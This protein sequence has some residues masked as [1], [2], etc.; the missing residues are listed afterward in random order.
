MSTSPRS[1]GFRPVIVMWGFPELSQTFIHREIAGWIA[2]HPEL[3]ILAGARR[4]LDRADAESRGW[5]ERRTTWLPAP[6][7]WFPRGLLRGMRRPGRFLPALAWMLALPHRTWLHRLRGAA[8]CVAAADA[9]PALLRMRA[10]YLHAHFASYHTEW[11]MCLA[12]MAGVP[13]GG[14]WHAVDIWKDR[15]ILAE[16]IRGAALVLTCTR[17]NFGYLRSLAPESA[18]T[19]K[20]AYHGI[21]FDRLGVPTPPPE[22]TPVILAIGRLVEKKGFHHLLDA[23]AVL[24]DEG[25]AF[26]LRVVGEGPWEAR[27]REQ[28]VL[29]GLAD[30]VEW[31]GALPNAET[32]DAVRAS[33]VLAAP[34]IPAAD[35]D[36][37]GIPNVILEAMALARPV[38]GADFSGIPEVV[39]DGVTGRLVPPG[40]AAALA[41]ALADVLAHREMAARLGAAG[42]AF[43]REHFDAATNARRQ[44]ELVY[45]A[46]ES[47][48]EAGRRGGSKS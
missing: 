27:L 4:P 13:W 26:R 18:R 15:N 29:L 33:T 11:A 35:G 38:V 25:V 42:A 28:S 36:I 48:E 39:R 20:L 31:L 22:G 5:A 16:K 43:V 1:P 44:L 24:R 30:R 37:D 2:A 47:R 34:S 17:H 41:R 10:D 9:L 32:L 40:D 23:C 45:A 8:M 3:R 14:S 19:V 12:R 46:L 6:W 21:R 7:I